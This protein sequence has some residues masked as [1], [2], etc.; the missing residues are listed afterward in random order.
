MPV[1]HALINKRRYKQGTSEASPPACDIHTHYILCYLVHMYGA[2]YN[3]RIYTV[4]PENLV[5][6]ELNLAVGVHNCLIE[7]CQS[8]LCV[9][10]HMVTLYRT[11]K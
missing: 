11:S 7:I 6:G 3:I 1:L 10:V 8:F 9:Y 4:Q 2:K 5:A